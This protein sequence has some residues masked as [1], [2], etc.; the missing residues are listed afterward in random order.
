MHTNQLTTVAK[1]ATEKTRHER[2]QKF[3]ATRNATL[4]PT[5]TA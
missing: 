3:M 4:G 1:K 5:Q 2:Q